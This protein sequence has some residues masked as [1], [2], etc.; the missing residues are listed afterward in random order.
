MCEVKYS[1]MFV[2]GE[3]FAT[4]LHKP[5]SHGRLD[6]EVGCSCWVI[7]LGR[8]SNVQGPFEASFGLP[9]PVSGDLPF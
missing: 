9:D 5:P 4:R 7:L 3:S 8:P 6:L 2:E 1:R